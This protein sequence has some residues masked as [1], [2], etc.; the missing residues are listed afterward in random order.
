MSDKYRPQ[1]IKESGGKGD[2]GAASLTWSDTKCKIAFEELDTTY[3]VM[4]E[5]LPEYAQEWNLENAFVTMNGD[6]EEVFSMRPLSGVFTVRTS[7][8][9]RQGDADEPPA[10]QQRTG[11]YGEYYTFNALLEIIKGKF[12]GA[13][14]PMYLYYKFADY[15][16]VVGIKG[17]GASSMKLMDF[18]DVAGAWDEGEMEYDDNILPALEKRIK[19]AKKQFQIVVKKGYVESVLEVEIESDDEEETPKKKHADEDDE[20]EKPKK[21]HVVEEEEEEVKPKKKRVVED[22]DD[23]PPT[24]KKSVLKKSDDDEL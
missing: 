17:E 15:D 20:E 24:K 5:D 14:Y 19:K 8:F 4:R 12:S 3:K 21:K 6:N 13:I 1:V 16:G 23:D 9:S 11:K 7:G 2:N 22:D 18:L 10:P